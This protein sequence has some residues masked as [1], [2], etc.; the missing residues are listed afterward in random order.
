MGDSV[1]KPLTDV[2]WCDHLLVQANIVALSA[3][4]NLYIHNQRMYLVAEEGQVKLL[5]PACF[6]KSIIV[7]AS[8]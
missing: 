2:V 5:C 3:V 6:L 8:H 7:S 4:P 1:D